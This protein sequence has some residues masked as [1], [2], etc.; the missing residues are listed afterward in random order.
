M[1]F[2]TVG[3]LGIPRRATWLHGSDG[4]MGPHGSG[5]QWGATVLGRPRR[6]K[7]R[8][9]VASSLKFKKFLIMPPAYYKYDDSEVIEFYTKVI[10]S[11]P[12][13]KIILYNFE[14]LCGYKFSVGCVEELVK[15]YPDQMIGVKAS[16]YNLYKNLK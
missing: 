8:R 6:K 5:A 4:P 13:C 11:I 16:T 2:S 7:E 9:K 14:K 12:E 15:N 10:Q 1:H 3:Y